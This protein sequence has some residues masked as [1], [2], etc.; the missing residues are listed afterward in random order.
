MYRK[1]FD[2]DAFVSKTYRNRIEELVKAVCAKY[3]LGRRM[4]ALLTRE[5]GFAGRQATDWPGSSNERLPF[6]GN[7]TSV[8]ETGS[9]PHPIRIDGSK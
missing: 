1:R 8:L 7:G 5:V 2:S 3:S 6:S 9:R 4:D